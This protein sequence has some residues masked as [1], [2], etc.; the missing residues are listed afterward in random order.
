MKN[1]QYVYLIQSEYYKELCQEI[2]KFLHENKEYRC[3]EI[4]YFSMEGIDSYCSAF[5]LMEKI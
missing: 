4:K 2:N 5:L 1:N 3:A